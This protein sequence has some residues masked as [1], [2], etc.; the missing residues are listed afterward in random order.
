MLQKNLRFAAVLLALALMRCDATPAAIAT[1]RPPP[2]PIDWT[3]V[4]RLVS[5]QKLEAAF[6]E[7]TRLK[8]R[9]QMSGNEAEWARALVKAVQLRTAL[10]GY[11][12]AVEFLRKEPWPN[13]PL[14]RVTLELFYG[15]AI[16]TYLQMYG[17]EVRQREKVESAR[18]LDLEKW[19]AEQLHTEALR[20]YERAWAMRAEQGTR[21]VGDLGEFIQPNDYPANIRSTLRDAIS[22]LAVEILV[23][24][25]QWTPAH[26][27]ELF[28][29][30][31]PSLAKG[32]AND[33]AVESMSDPE[34]H[35]LVRMGAVLD[36]LEAWHQK[37]GRIEAAMEARFE[38]LRR[39]HQAFTEPD[40]R[41]LLRDV[42]AE[43]LKSNRALPWWSVGQALLAEM[44]RD[45]GDLVAA[46]R[47]AAEGHE[48]HPNS[49]GG[50][51]CLHIAG[52]IEQP[53]YHLHS[54]AND[55]AGARSLMLTHKNVEA[56]HFRAYA[57]DIEDELKNAS[58]RSLGL[59]PEEMRK[60]LS[61]AEPTAS[62][63]VALRPTPDFRTHRTFVTP[64]FEGHGWY[65]V[66]A[67]ARE[68]FAE[69]ENVVIATSLL[70][71]DL[72]L[73]TSNDQGKLEATVF[74]SASGQPVA[75]A[76]VTFYEHHWMQGL[77]ALATKKTDRHGVVKFD[78]GRQGRSV[79]AV[80]RHGG[81]VLLDGKHRYVYRQA[82]NK[83]RK[84]ALVYTDRSI[85][86]PG[87]KLLWKAIAWEGRADSA[88]LRTLPKKKLTITLLDPNWQ[89]AAKVDAVTNEFG[90]VAGAFE[91]PA[92]RPLGRWT[93]R[94]SIGGDKHLRVEEYKRP[95]FEVKIEAPSEP[96]RINRPANLRGEA[97]YYFG[98]PVTEGD[99]RWRV[100]RQPVYPW[101]W[102][103]WG[104]DAN[105]RTQTISTGVS[106]VEQDGSFSVRFTP[107]ADER[108]KEGFSWNYVLTADLT[109]EGGETRS[110]TRSFRI[111]TVA[112]EAT[113]TNEHA[114]LRDG[115]AEKVRV[116]RASLDGAPRPGQGSWS[117]KALKAP[118]TALLPADLPIP[119]RP[120][121][122]GKYRTDG[123]AQRPRWETSF[124]PEAVMSTWPDGSER[125][126]GKLIHDE[127]GV[128]EIELPP[129]RPG[130]YR[131]RYETVDEFGAKYDTWKIFVVHGARLHLPLPSM[132]KAEKTTVRAGETARVLI[133]SGL[134]DQ[135]LRVEIFRSGKLV[136][137]RDMEGTRL[138]EIPV[139]NEYRGGFGVRLTAVRDHQLM[140]FS[141][142]IYV[143]WD[144]RELG[145][146]FAT[147]RDL[148]RP[149]AKETFRV[150]VK[151][152]RG[153][154]AAMRAAE[155]LGYM[156]D[157]SLD[158][159]APHSAPSPL[160]LLPTRTGTPSIDSS[161]SG[162][163]AQ[164]V[165]GSHRYPGHYPHLRGDQLNFLES[166]GIGGMGMRGGYG[167]GVVSKSLRAD[168]LGQSRARVQASGLLKQEAAMPAPSA[169]P[170]AMTADAEEAPAREE[171]PAVQIRSE[172][173]ETAF[174][175]PQLL[176]GK[177]GSA[178][179]EFTVP[180]S[181]TSWNVWVH[182]VT[183]DLR[184]GSLH[185]EARSAKELMVR[186][187]VPRFFR[188]GDKAELKV[189]VNN[190]SDRPL[191][192][193][194]TLDIHDAETEE[195]L[196]SAFQLDSRS[197][198][199][200]V[201]PGGGTTVSFPLVAPNRVGP[202]AFKVIA[203]AGDVS[204]GELR[205][206]P[207]LPSRYHLAQSRFVTLRDKEQRTL[208]FADLEKDD[209]TRLNDRLVVTLD[210]QLFFTVLKA[211][212]YLVEYP[213]ECAEQT[214][215][216][217]LS[218]GIVT[219][220]FRENPT[221]AAMAREFSARDTAFEPWD[222][223]DPNL[224]MG[225]EETPWLRTARGGTTDRALIRVL[226]PKVARS[227]QEDALAK[228]RKMQLSNGAF[229][230]FPGGPPS[231]YI[232]LYLMHGF[233][234]A[235]EFG[236]DVPKDVVQ[237]GWQYLGTHYRS[238]INRWLKDE[239]CWEFLT[240]LN[241]V[242]SAYPDPSWT[243]GALTDADRKRILEFTF[244]RWKKH[245]PFLKGYLALTL[246]RMG[247]GKDAR[248][249]FESVLDSAKTEKDLGTFWAQESRSWLWYNDTIE[250]HAFALRTL[251]ELQPDHPK[252]DGLVLWLLLNKK[253]SHWKSTRATAEVIYSLVHYLK[254][255]KSLGIR[256]E[257]HVQ[258]GEERQTFVFEPDVYVGKSQLVLPPQKID[259]SA[260][261]ISV[262]KETK[263]L[264]F[265]SATWHFS[266]EQLPEEERGDFFHVSR[267]Y[268]H[269][270]HDGREYVLRPLAEGATLTP[271]DEVEVHLTLRTKHAAEY[272]HLRDPRP[273]GLEPDV[274]VSRYK[275]DLG[276]AWYE[277]IRDSG[278]NFFF[279]RLPVGEYNFRYRVRANMGGSFRVGPAIVQS[280]Y[281][282]EFV[283]YSA[284]HVV[285]VASR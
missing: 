212:P 93:L 237:R 282:P 10:H 207:V 101:W 242:A 26:S 22:Y 56:L 229:P 236:V 52:S 269:R 120:G 266:T 123:D 226:D 154:K 61:F 186:P 138:V 131:L 169:A 113:I 230:W 84:S 95:T 150:T 180:D 148:L 201:E 274:A 190:A 118:S 38:R 227:Q 77:L 96:L 171:P 132:M 43:R 51:R 204:D 252:K 235:A 14:A 275:W 100:T 82:E 256:E 41:R 117:L 67:S 49:I 175:E 167:R 250:S 33:G 24:S 78:P 156:Y 260:A 279:E 71:S 151:A 98:L 135:P 216:R 232:T 210:G 222:A 163:G 153:E 145:V 198:R 199:F 75:G 183:K 194:F 1:P 102:S 228:L 7:V 238:E 59:S 66:L 31:L 18:E 231:P 213:Y 17:W 196:A 8:E 92:G 4:D 85:Y 129:L 74:D 68:D 241:Y 80:V 86:R 15:R 219:Q 29:I 39:L 200:E 141:E 225:L 220:V 206:V 124:T 143:P 50:A 104:Y 149:G 268:Y 36:D 19:T 181:V 247:R 203:R 259:R 240:F 62:W 106:K 221:I 126:R 137:R 99:V 116:T 254:E 46:H 109:D 40:D 262:E 21:P 54:M 155:L 136:E 130:A 243:A 172:F 108:G 249:V 76:S 267:R 189:V 176:A 193:E 5:E 239:C 69:E 173:A 3:E 257:A 246:H 58:R 6:E 245:S 128:A 64:P 81:Q 65:F 125:A 264:M 263:G 144:D 161:L 91:I 48:A 197:R 281:A 121:D 152:P 195:D 251:M 188:E 34:V 110:A 12:T 162:R 234:K 111:G 223:E 280:M 23:D 160:G 272:V 16:L 184:A 11:E 284:G 44:V 178:V 103:W 277:E 2:E 97:R 63:K 211:L 32:P 177:D 134:A 73:V 83:N 273:A 57:V 45:S 215:N 265:A 94:T 244:G 146:E 105:A 112:V 185:R 147:F 35:P 174:W 20:A 13:E 192:G 122:E 72:V 119:V 270:V 140:T 179:I 139:S 182:A 30:D 191:S 278:T 127:T 258:L 202:A 115:R 218:T 88:D 87:Q 187:Y 133:H 208:H 233:A 9:A 253:L 70:I 209:P 47:L 214:M 89:E 205:P 285:N 248:L 255:E 142:N 27:N 164:H 224:R 157:R 37:A 25:A 53:E 283:A 168:S 261:T 55:R 60:L 90:S 165:T 276:I 271:G 217:F 107:E 114:F 170:L 28:R 79:L 42:L 158:A 166:Y 159:F